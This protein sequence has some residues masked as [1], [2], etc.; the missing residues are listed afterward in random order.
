MGE[1]KVSLPGGCAIGTRPVD[2][3]IMAMERLGAL[4]EIEGGYAVARAPKGGLKG[5]EIFFPKVTVGG[6]H[7]AVMAASLANGTTVIQN[8][9]ASPR[10][11]TSPPASSPW[12]RKSR[13]REHP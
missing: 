6:T 5:A 2:F 1:A 12:A 11:P 13:A 3:L 7:M 4:I 10:S 9:R 8:V